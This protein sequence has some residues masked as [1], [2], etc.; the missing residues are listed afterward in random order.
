M[1]ARQRLNCMNFDDW[2]SEPERGQEL[3]RALNAARAAAKGESDEEMAIYFAQAVMRRAWNAACV[4]C[5]AALH[6]NRPAEHRL[7]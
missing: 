4:E 5:Y 3:Q 6:E 1:D 2:F 7:H